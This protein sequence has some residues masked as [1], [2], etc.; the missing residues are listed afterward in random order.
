MR[1]TLLVIVVL[2]VTAQAYA[3]T[4]TLSAND[5]SVGP[6][7][8]AS[9]RY[10]ADANVSAFALKIYADSGALIT[11][12]ADYN[13]GEC[14]ATVQGY[15]IFPGT[16]DINEDTGVVE[17]NGT[18]I[19]PSSDPCNHAGPTGIG[20]D[21]IIVEM[22]ALYEDGNEPA[23]SGTLL[24]VKVDDD[25]N[26]CV[27]TES[28]RGNVVLTDANE[29]TVIYSPNC[30]TLQVHYDF[31][32]ADDPPYP[33]LLASNGA[34]HVATG[35]MLG[36][37]R[38]IE[39]NGQPSV[40]CDLD[41]NTGV[42]DDEDGIT[43][44]VATPVGGS[45]TVTVTGTCLL[46][47][48]IDFTNDGDWVDAGE[49]IFTDQPL[50]AGPNTLAFAVPAGAVKETDLISRWRI[51]TAGGDSYE[52]EADDGEVEDYNQPRIVCHVPDVVG[53]PCSAAIAELIANGFTIGNITSANSV[54][55]E[56]SAVISTNPGDC[57]YPG[58]GTAVDIV[59][60][61]GCTYQGPAPEDVNWVAVGKPVSW[62]RDRQC[63]GDADGATE[64][65][66]RK[67]VWVGDN[68]IPALLAGYKVTTYVDPITNPW[69]SADFDHLPEKSGRGWARVGTN[70][71]AVLL[72]YYKVKEP[73]DGLGVPADCNTASPVS[74]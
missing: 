18:P 51:S 32:D 55:I 58:C 8:W 37:N 7:R 25:C 38:D 24:S 65:S 14:N 19:A 59:V 33:T 21:T 60:S 30:V 1:K 29:A 66:G 56:L 74:P 68:D 34:R 27:E 26:V 22:G 4:V 46:N 43:A 69:I 73:P 28:I 2:F 35:P 64:Q 50:V 42:P 6:D 47:A 39:L 20:E 53:D 40:N 44:L 9:I 11:A 62:C 12:I 48:W 15:G 16:I 17:S 23:L 67:Q 31:G 49:Q 72:V 70:D 54:V 52:D 41:D 71:V 5:V 13:V 36:A 45:V 3:G 61:Q 57:N 63:H 10:S